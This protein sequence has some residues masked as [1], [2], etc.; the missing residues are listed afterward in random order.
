MEEWLRLKFEVVVIHMKHIPNFPVEILVGGDLTDILCQPLPPYSN[1]AIAFLSELS[2]RLLSNRS[3]HSH[4]DIAG[5]AYWCRRSNLARLERN[6]DAKKYRLGRGLAFHIAPANVP[7]NF[8][9]SLAFGLIAGNANIV[10]IPGVKHI[11][12]S[13]ICAEIAELLRSPKHSRIAKMTRVI[14][15]PRDDLITEALSMACHT[16]VLWGGDATIG[17]LRAMRTSPRCMDICF[18]DRYSICIMG[19]DRIL[20]A[21]QSILDGLIAG[22]YNDVFLLDQNA[23][24]SPHLVLWQGGGEEIKLAKTKFWQATEKHLLSKQVAQPIYAIDKYAHLCRIAIELDDCTLEQSNSIYR[25]Q[26]DNLPQ[27][28]EYYRGRHGFFFENTCND[29]RVLNPIINQRYQTVTYFGI[30]PKVIM[31]WVMDAGLTGVDR[32]VPVG[33]ALDIGV[34]WD[35]YELIE[36]LSRIIADS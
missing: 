21:N 17:H 31:D 8:A 12:V 35:G 9:F 28:I 7:V 3:I 36:T 13:I 16:R 27:N 23:C 5:F 26:L 22:F 34:I 33:K 24:S 15:Y 14:S 20:D 10:R 32:I 1:E 19:A 11:Q 25:V 6:F 29:L 18:A 2:L 4:P 30:N